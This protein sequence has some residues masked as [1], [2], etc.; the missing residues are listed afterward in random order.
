MVLQKIIAG[1]A[2][3]ILSAVIYYL[4]G[5][6]D[7]TIK[8]KLLYGLTSGFLLLSAILIFFDISGVI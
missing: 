7:K 4:Y 1:L 3:I 2:C 5:N 6:S 8:S